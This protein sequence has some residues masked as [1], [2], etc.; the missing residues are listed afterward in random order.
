MSVRYV[1]AVMLSVAYKIRIF[2]GGF[3][4]TPEGCWSNKI[5]KTLEQD[6]QIV[7]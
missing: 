7:S 5:H 4:H 2:V 1:A 6:F 3:P